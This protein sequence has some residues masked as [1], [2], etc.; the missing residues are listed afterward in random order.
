M[1]WK[2]ILRPWS[3]LRAAEKTCDDLY[4]NLRMAEDFAV[5]EGLFEEDERATGP[6]GSHLELERRF[7]KQTPGLPS[8]WTKR[9]R[10]LK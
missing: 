9:R 4:Y 2:S 5:E 10:G 6:D 3:A 7:Q 1:N 8:R